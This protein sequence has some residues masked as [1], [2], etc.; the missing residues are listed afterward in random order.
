MSERERTP[1]RVL[2]R[3]FA[4]GRA[5]VVPGE[6]MDA[7]TE[8]SAL[9][10]RARAEI[11]SERAAMRAE[12]A[13][14]RARVREELEEELVA[15]RI[16]LLVAAHRTQSEERELLAA[17]LAAA[18]IEVAERLLRE[19]LEVDPRRVQGLVRG[20]LEKLAR[21]RRVRVWVHAADL[22]AARSMPE[23]EGAT[24]EVDEELSRGSC[25]VD[26]EIGTADG[27]LEVRLAALGGALER[28]LARVHAAPPVQ[29][30]GQSPVQSSGQS[31]VQS[32]AGKRGA[33]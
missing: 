18:A 23:L 15:D 26:T 9:R 2:R 10:A 24:V 14:E 11:A 28:G 7:R 3:H 17:D 21:A 25:R 5:R 30:S 4:P 27:R 8:S 31:P 6:V 16:A 22:A 29:S 1:T 20:T 13:E 32:A 12:L 19:A 33:K